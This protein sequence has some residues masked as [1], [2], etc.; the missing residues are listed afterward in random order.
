MTNNSDLSSS[1]IDI[2]F[3]VYSLLLKNKQNT[4]WFY[5]FERKNN[6]CKIFWRTWCIYD[7]KIVYHNW[8]GY[9]GAINIEKNIPSVDM[10]RWIVTFTDGTICWY[11]ER[12]HRGE[13]S[14]QF[15]FSLHACTL[16]KS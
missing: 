16:S 2:E 5:V 13:S 12:S 14:I 15:T 10:Y 3:K 1:T 8:C 7:W 4:S 9:F 11:E 6:L